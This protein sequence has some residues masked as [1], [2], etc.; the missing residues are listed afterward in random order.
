MSNR[1]SC[2]NA[3]SSSTGGIRPSS[4]PAVEKSSLSRAKR[5]GWGGELVHEHHDKPAGQK[6]KRISRG[7]FAERLFADLA[8][9][10]PDA[11]A[12]RVG[13]PICRA[14]ELSLR[15]GPC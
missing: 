14:M 12:N 5:R 11:L 10:V 15:S 1:R 6:L 4:P 8:R 9:S 3:G 13:I 2:R 7:A